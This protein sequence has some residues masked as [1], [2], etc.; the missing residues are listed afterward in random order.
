MG[1]LA[2]CLS[3]CVFFF[4]LCTALPH[5]SVGGGLVDLVERACRG[6]SPCLARGGRGVFLASVPLRGVVHGLVVMF[7]MH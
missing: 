3:S 4:A 6:N 2:A 7:V 5:G 1:F